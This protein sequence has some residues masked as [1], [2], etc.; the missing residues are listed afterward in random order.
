M[1]SWPL[2]YIDRAVC[3]PL[4]VMT[5]EW[6]RLIRVA[7]VLFLLLLPGVKGRIL[8]QGILVGDGEHL[9][10]CP[11]VLHDDLVDQGG[12]HESLLKEHYD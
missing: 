6:A 7:R 12:V 1:M 4:L 2:H 10:R 11:G 3:F 5:L 8:S 9:F